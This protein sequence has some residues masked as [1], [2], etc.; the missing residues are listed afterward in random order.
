MSDSAGAG[1]GGTV[2]A[3]QDAEAET[4]PPLWPS[5][6]PERDGTE[7]GSMSEDAAFPSAKRLKMSEVTIA[8]LQPGMSQVCDDVKAQT[9][10]EQEEDSM[11][12]QGEVSLPPCIS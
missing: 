8:P 11:P 6:L 4:E 12:G 2:G 3:G 5:P 7:L 9:D 1:G 10:P